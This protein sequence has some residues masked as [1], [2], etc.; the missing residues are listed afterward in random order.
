MIGVVADDTTGANDIGLMF[1]NNQ[2]SVKVMTFSEDMQLE[3]DTDVLIIDTDS[4]LDP[5]ELSYDK[6]FK[7][8]KMLERLGC[9]LY[10][11]KTCSVFRGNIG[12]E[13]DAMMDA[14]QENF[15]VII[16]AFPKYGRQTVNGIHTVYG[17]LLEESNFAKDPV[18]P[19]TQSN[20]VSIL[21]GQTER[22]VSQIDLDIVRQG[23]GALRQALHKKSK[24]ANYCI[25]D[26][27]DQNDIKIVAEA[28]HTYRVLC[29][30]SAIAEELP[31]FLPIKKSGTV[32]DSLQINDQNGV[33][34]IS[35]SLTPQTKA[36]TAYL[37]SRGTSKVVLDS[38]KIFQD[39]EYTEELGRVTRTA[40]QLL[41]DGKDVLVMAA[42]GEDVIGETKELGKKMSMD[43]LTISKRVSA[44]LAEITEKLVTG[45]ELK[46][47]VVAGGDTSGTVCRKLGIKGNYILREIEIG[48]PSGLAIGRNMLIVLKS[49]SFGKEDF[50]FK[51]VQHLKLV[52]SNK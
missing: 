17:K 22:K 4:R 52:S 18:H 47:L 21:Q 15:A 26:S 40:E 36:Q 32:F 3:R 1:R 50:L 23:P 41:K 14:L 28:V 16:L 31:K 12:K 25:I 8:T 27:V 39:M 46:R 20:L 2:C 11:K 5:P 44:A 49:G 48:L 43:L 10:F 6:V 7:A 35:G 34:V 24:I 29:G 37:V 13:F 9:S 19:M 45:T 33:L 51:A 30:S 38:R 42:N